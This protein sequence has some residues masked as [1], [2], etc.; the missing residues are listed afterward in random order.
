VAINKPSGKIES[1]GKS[2]EKKVIGGKE[3]GATRV[4]NNDRN[5]A[6]RSSTGKGTS[7]DGERTHRKSAKKRS[8]ETAGGGGRGEVEGVAG[9]EKP[10]PRRRKRHE[11][12]TP[13][14]I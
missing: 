6:G 10:A 2:R 11:K 12:E 7:K 9:G 5:I 3:K 14:K 1:R 13:E 8:G 4:L